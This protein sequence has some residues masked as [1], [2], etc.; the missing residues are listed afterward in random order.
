MFQPE[1]HALT[2]S[3]DSSEVGRKTEGGT[4]PT[5]PASTHTKKERGMMGG[6]ER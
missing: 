5:P 1:V 4:I 3:G 6:R 2:T